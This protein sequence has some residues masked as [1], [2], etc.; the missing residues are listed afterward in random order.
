[1]PP[2]KLRSPSTS[3]ESNDLGE[4]LSQM[5]KK[6]RLDTTAETRMQVDAPLAPSA[7]ASLPKDTSVQIK[8]I[9]IN[10]E[11]SLKLIEPELIKVNHAFEKIMLLGTY[12][13]EYE[14][15][16]KNLCKRLKSNGQ[17][18]Y[19]TH[20]EDYDVSE[21]IKNIVNNIKELQVALNI[22]E[23]FNDFSNSIQV[24]INEENKEVKS[25]NFQQ[26]NL[27]FFLV[28]NRLEEEA[29]SDAD[30]QNIIKAYKRT[31]PT[32]K[33]TKTEADYFIKFIR[34]NSKMEIILKSFGVN[35]ITEMLDAKYIYLLLKKGLHL[36]QE[37][38]I[39]KARIIFGDDFVAKYL[40]DNSLKLSSSMSEGGAMRRAR[41]GGK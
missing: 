22:E 6:T 18:I 21:Y 16:Y 30:A 33:L 32:Y 35:Y 38:S 19:Y 37:N 27:P 8:L 17:F 15:S 23:R 29:L 14:V 11:R 9:N 2:K 28:Y 4:D 26:Y 25:K 10:K 40:N 41:R 24:A 7:I 12:L 20:F 13:K 34:I 5:L 39:E 1:M 31:F 36:N 3:P